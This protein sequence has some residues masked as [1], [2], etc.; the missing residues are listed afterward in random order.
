MITEVMAKSVVEYKRS[1][2]F[3]SGM[4]YA[5]SSCLVYRS[6]V[7]TIFVSI[8]IGYI[9]KGMYVFDKEVL[10]FCC[11]FRSDGTY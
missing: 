10:K 7:N 1:V 6:W 5:N 11:F 3:W 2:K 8:Y 4:S 9:E